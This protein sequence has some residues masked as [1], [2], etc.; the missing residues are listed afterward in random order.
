MNTQRAWGLI[1]LVFTATLLLACDIANL[2]GVKSPS[3][4]IGDV[5][6]IPTAS[7]PGVGQSPSV[8]EHLK[9]DPQKLGFP[10]LPDARNCQHL[11][12]ITNFQTALSPQDAIII[13]N[14]LLAKEGWKRKDDGKLPGMG[15]WTKGTQQLNIVAAM[16]KGATTVQIQEVGTAAPAPTALSRTATPALTSGARATAPAPTRV[17]G[18]VTPMP[19]SRIYVAPQDI[20]IKPEPVQGDFVW[21]G[22]GTKGETINFCVY[23]NSVHRMHYVTPVVCQDKQTRQTYSVWYNLAPGDLPSFALYSTGMFNLNL[24]YTIPDG[25]YKDCLLYTS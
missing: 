8:A 19:T 18:G 25:V 6:I 2:I 17:A 7:S 5:V 9:C 1:V 13:Y 14:E 16:E 4:S 3:P 12:I 24:E 20:T 21:T 10:L 23:R 22:M 11:D 15:S